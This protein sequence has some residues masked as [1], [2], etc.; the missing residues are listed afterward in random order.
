MLA[1]ITGLA[2]HLNAS[3][4]AFQTVTYAGVAYLLYPK[5]TLLFFASAVRR[6]VATR[7]HVM[8]RMNKGFAVSY[9]ALGVRLAGTAR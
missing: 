5:L 1:A 7:P 2:A 3:A 4:L 9:V 6:H 8:R